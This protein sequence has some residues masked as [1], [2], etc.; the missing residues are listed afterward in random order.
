V[1][2][3]GLLSLIMHPNQQLLQN[4]YKAFDRKDYATMQQAYHPQAK[5]Y[6]PVFQHL[7]AEEAKAM[8][9]MLLTSAKDLSVKFSECQADDKKG[10]IR[11]DAYYTFTKTG[12]KVHNIIHATFAFHEGK[13]VDH[14]DHFDLW[15]WSRQALGVSGMLLGWSP[16]VQNKVRATAKASLRKFMG[17]R[18]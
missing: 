11:W 7:N 13:I 17:E 1:I 9:Q 4:F 8:W 14:H 2:A 15:R 3:G 6:D 5:F 10:S 12:R 16:V 18:R